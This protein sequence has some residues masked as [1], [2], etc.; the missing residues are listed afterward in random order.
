MSVAPIKTT[1]VAVITLICFYCRLQP[2]RQI[3][4]CRFGSSGGRQLGLRVKLL[5]S[6]FLAYYSIFLDVKQNVLNKLEAK[7]R[8]KKEM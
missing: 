4:Q 6:V 1:S 8:K 2:R 7:K 3:L 5:F